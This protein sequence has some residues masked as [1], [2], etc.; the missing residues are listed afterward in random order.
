MSALII[1]IERTSN[2]GNKPGRVTA[3]PCRLAVAGAR[4]IEK[5]VSIST[6]EPL[7][8]A[9]LLDRLIA[10]YSPSEL[11][12][13]PSRQR[14]MDKFDSPH[15]IDA[16]FQ[17]E[18]TRDDSSITVPLTGYAGP[19]A[20][21]VRKGDRRLV[22]MTPILA[23]LRRNNIGQVSHSILSLKAG[24]LGIQWIEDYVD[25]LSFAD[26]TGTN[27]A[28]SINDAFRD[29]INPL[30]TNPLVTGKDD[31]RFDAAPIVHSG[32]LEDLIGHTRA[33]MTL[34]TPDTFNPVAKLYIAS[35]SWQ[36]GDL[37]IEDS[38]DKRRMKA[39]HAIFALIQERNK[40]VAP[41]IRFDDI[42]SPARFTSYRR[43]QDMVDVAH[44]NGA[45]SGHERLAAANLLTEAY[46]EAFTKIY[47]A[48]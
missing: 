47:D 42:G 15:A 14:L 34:L 2:R 41:V 38:L 46:G 8:E 36:D 44:E 26:L 19:A 13:A 31:P 33:M 45:P 4:T 28:R 25:G 35:Q 32:S 21:T 23:W 29:T 3:R 5:P 18:T 17:G 37:V 12:I 30:L 27:A 39:A 16:L 43:V 6:A 22:L 24:T 9:T 20:L 10:Q 11:M 1:Q 7:A 48:L 40:I